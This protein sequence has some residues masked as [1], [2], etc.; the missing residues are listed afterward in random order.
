MRPSALTDNRPRY[1]TGSMTNLISPGSTTVSTLIGGP[2]V[3][4][5]PEVS[6]R[7]AAQTLTGADVGIVVVGDSTRA[8]GVVS[9]RDVTK[10]VAGGL[11]LD[12]TRAVDIAHASLLWCDATSTV[13]EVAAE[14]MD[15]WV[16]HVLVEERGRLVG[17][18]SA[19]DLLGLYLSGEEI[20]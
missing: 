8:T 16:R 2:V 12:A 17:V 1:Q 15:Q 19:R 14:M 10:A 3:R 6:I 11:D 20:D 5:A 4:I 13:A 7:Q 9:E 18:V